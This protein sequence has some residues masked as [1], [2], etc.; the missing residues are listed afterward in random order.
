MPINFFRVFYVIII[1]EQRIFD[2]K[3]TWCF[4]LLYYWRYKIETKSKEWAL[5]KDVKWSE[6]L[7]M[8][9]LLFYMRPKV[10]RQSV[11]NIIYEKDK[12]GKLRMRTIYSTQ[13]QRKKRPREI[14]LLVFLFLFTYL[15][16]RL[17]ALGN[18]GLR[19]EWL[20]CVD[21]ARIDIEKLSVHNACILICINSN[22]QYSKII[23]SSCNAT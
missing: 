13:Y 7:L 16:V 4:V 5:T 20:R 11:R 18:K 12:K 15:F 3:P 22:L 9:P 8:C 10:F 2:R 6:Q 17:V 21:G 1:N 23:I 19:Y 14:N